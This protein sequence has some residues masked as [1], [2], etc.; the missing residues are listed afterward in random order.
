MKRGQ[1]GR[2]DPSRQ[3]G[4]PSLPLKKEPL[5]VRPVFP[6]LLAKG[7]E[8]SRFCEGRGDCRLKPFQKEAPWGPPSPLGPFMLSFLPEPPRRV[9]ERFEV[10]V[11][12]ATQMGKASGVRCMRVCLGGCI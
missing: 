7:G 4:T 3:T 1:W 12:V 8:E 5:W 11:G 2:I 9:R 6:L 10:R